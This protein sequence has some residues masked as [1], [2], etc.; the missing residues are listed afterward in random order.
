MVAQPSSGLVARAVIDVPSKHL[1]W[2]FSRD[3]A[4]PHLDLT[5]FA[6]DSN[7]GLFAEYDHRLKITNVFR[8]SKT[9]FLLVL[10]NVFAIV[11]CQM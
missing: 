2:A 10:V 6:I 1:N 3:L 11:A 9:S 8:R 7:I 4:K 5:I